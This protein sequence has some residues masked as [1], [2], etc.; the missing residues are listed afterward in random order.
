[1]L[2]KTTGTHVNVTYITFWWLPTPNPQRFPEYFLEI[3]LAWFS[4]TGSVNDSHGGF[5]VCCESWVWNR[6]S[7]HH[8][9]NKKEETMAITCNNNDDI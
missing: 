8:K 4:S 7:H 9:Q 3:L 5:A 1:M 2:R 6:P